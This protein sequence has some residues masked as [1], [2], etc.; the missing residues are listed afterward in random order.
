MYIRTCEHIHVFETHTSSTALAVSVFATSSATPC[1]N[2]VVR[3]SFSF[4]VRDRASFVLG[5]Q[6]MYWTLNK[7]SW[8]VEPRV[9]LDW[10]VGKHHRLSLGYGWNS[11]IQSFAMSFLVRKQA[12]GSYDDGNRELG[13]NRSH[14]LA[15][16]YDASLSRVWGIKANA[17]GSYNT[18]LAV[19][20]TKNSF[21]IVNYG[22]FAVYP[23][24]TSLVSEGKA[25]NYGIEISIEKF[26]SKGFYGLL[27]SA[28]QRSIYQGSDEVWRNSAFDAQ[29]VTS[30]VM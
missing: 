25:V 29:H 30:L 12:D 27:S 23:D 26:F 13:L 18:N 28:Y 5:V 6:G 9:A 19:D 16:S 8:A 4:G 10:R 1:F 2:A 22:N 20:Q 14:Q 24:S 15:L 7:N 17:Y 3:A 11:K 21:S